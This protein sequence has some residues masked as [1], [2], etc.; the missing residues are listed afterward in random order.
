MDQAFKHMNLWR[1]SSS[2]HQR[3]SYLLIYS[4]KIHILL[5]YFYYYDPYINIGM[6]I[7]FE[8]FIFGSSRWLSGYR[9]LWPSVNTQVL[10]LG[11]RCWKH[12]CPLISTQI[13]GMWTH[14]Y[15]CTCI[16]TLTHI[17]IPTLSLTHTHSGK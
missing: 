17:Y 9:H 14:T 11:S 12:K 13:C 8:D 4:W 1:P 15:A 6:Q 10:S 7:Y 2:N 16:H 5:S 3:H